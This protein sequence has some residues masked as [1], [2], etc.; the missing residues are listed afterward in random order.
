[1]KME[2]RVLSEGSRP[3]FLFFVGCVVVGNAVNVQIA[4]VCCGQWLWR[5]FKNS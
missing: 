5:N 1:M 4:W 3:D 2:A